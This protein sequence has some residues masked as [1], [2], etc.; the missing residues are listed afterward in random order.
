MILASVATVQERKKQ[1]KKRKKKDWAAVGVFLMAD[2][3]CRVT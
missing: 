1:E 3:A 2:S